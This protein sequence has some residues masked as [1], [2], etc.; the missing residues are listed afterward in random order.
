MNSKEVRLLTL[1]I[2][3]KFDVLKY[4]EPKDDTEE[5]SDNF[6]D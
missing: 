4:E 3:R 1:Q 6:K 2:L 5:V